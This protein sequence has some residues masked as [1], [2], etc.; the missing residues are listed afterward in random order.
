MYGRGLSPVL[1]RNLLEIYHSAWEIMT[2]GQ[3]LPYH[4]LADATVAI[5]VARG[6]GGQ[7]LQFPE[8]CP[9]KY[10]FT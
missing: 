1:S 7:L 9:E 8:S 10:V 3:M 5:E 6:F 4:K 2:L